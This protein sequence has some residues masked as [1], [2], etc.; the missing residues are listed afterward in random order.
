M[1]HTAYK[2]GDWLVEPGLKRLSK[3]NRAIEIEPKTMAV[4]MLLIEHAGEVVSTAQI[5]SAVWDDRPMGD[6]PVYKTIARL[7][8]VLGDN[9]SN[10]EYIATV[11]KLG[12]RLLAPVSSITKPATGGSNASP[13]T[14]NIKTLL[15]G[16]AALFLLS[17]SFLL[18]H[19]PH[20]TS[21]NPQTRQLVN[22]PGS[23]SQATFAPGGQ[24]VAFINNAHGQDQ[25]WLLEIHSGSLR[26]LT[27]GD[28]HIHAPSWSPK[29]DWILFEKNGDIWRMQLDH[30][31]ELLMKQASNPAWA[32]DG[33]R[34]VFERGSEVW[35]SNADGMGQQRIDELTS[36]SQ[37]F[38][39]RQPVFSPDGGS[40][41]Y[42]E[43]HEGPQGDLWKFDFDTR[44]SIQ[45]TFDHK[46]A[47]RPV[48]T[49]DG[50]WIVFHSTRGGAQGLWRLDTKGGTSQPVLHSSGND[51]LCAI[52]PDGKSLVFA[53][54]R[55]S[56]SL[57]LTDPVNDAEETL[58]SSRYPI[59][60]PEI[61][62]DQTQI[63]FFAM[64][65][66]GGT[67]IFLLPFDKIVPRQITSTSDH[68]MPKW[69]ASGEWIY[70][71]FSGDTSGWG[72]I[73]TTNQE[74]ETLMS[75]WSFNQQHD[76]TISPDGLRAVYAQIEGN[77]V[78]HTKLK[79]MT[80]G[81]ENILR[82]KL[83]WPDW[84]S[85]GMRLLATDFSS[86]EI[87]VGSIV[88][89]QF[90]SDHIETCDQLAPHGQHPVWSTDESAAYFVEPV[91][92]EKLL[93]WRHDFAEQ[94]N[95]LVR[96]LT[97]AAVDL[98]PFID[99]SRTGEIVWVS[100]SPG[101]SELWQLTW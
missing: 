25:M 39:P 70:Q 34:I 82:H 79:H 101:R 44:E 7:R 63:A 81:E 100:F 9:A 52:A 36:R 43:N 20:P 67:N 99:V 60:A 4:L 15:F 78:L 66:K 56:W 17:I 49:P 48:F 37:L 19:E 16:I 46:I 47:G 90:D 18:L 50:D 3:D 41:V 5:I 8:Q 71:Y 74:S 45:L 14:L 97:P 89:C 38:A 31:A 10:P 27:F 28:E 94:K 24:Q 13:R 53:S 62:P 64:S 61:S 51:A 2:L 95:K 77:H 65:E 87:P 42:F 57:L 59:A 96:E 75:D 11:T 55:P 88:L 35:L 54:T 22:L 98:A 6:N 1:A 21:V 33:S 40:L 58:Y 86:S 68:I 73:N 76:V 26:Q 23:S 92:S 80:T 29:G 30:P 84:S 83:S 93:V 32:H 12:Y 85:D 72:R 91:S 69:S